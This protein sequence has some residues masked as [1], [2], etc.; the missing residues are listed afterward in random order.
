MCEVMLKLTAFLIAVRVC[1]LLLN[2]K[3]NIMAS[4]YIDGLFEDTNQWIEQ[5]ER[6]VNTRKGIFLVEVLNID[7]DQV[8]RKFEIEA[9]GNKHARSIWRSKNAKY[10]NE[11]HDSGLRIGLRIGR[12][13]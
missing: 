9:K 11:L 6:R 2:F 7:T 8:L 10:R 4:D 3:I 1:Y 13:K 5:P 12:A